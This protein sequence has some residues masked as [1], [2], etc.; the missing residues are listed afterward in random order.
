MFPSRGP[1][2][3]SLV[4]ALS[5][6]RRLSEASLRGIV[7]CSVHFCSSYYVLPSVFSGLTLLLIIL[8]Y[9]ILSY[10]FNFCFTLL[11]YVVTKLCDLA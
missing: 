7:F 11:S 4:G 6:L 8:L 5:P 2:A 9:F 1:R 10:L 3:V